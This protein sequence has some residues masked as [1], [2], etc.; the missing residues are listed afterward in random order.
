MPV[1]REIVAPELETSDGRRAPLGDDSLT[2]GG[3]G[4]LAGLK[5][6]MSQGLGELG[7]GLHW[8]VYDADGIDSCEDGILWL[9]YGG[10][11]YEYRTPI[12]GCVR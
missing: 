10:E 9:A 11:R 2:P 4:L 1:A 12:P 7:E 8:F 6:A 3:I 5:A